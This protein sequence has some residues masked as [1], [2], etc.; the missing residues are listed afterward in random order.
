MCLKE[1]Y[2]TNYLNKWKNNNVTIGRTIETYNFVIYKRLIISFRSTILTEIIG[3]YRL[4]L[5]YRDLREKQKTIWYCYL[6]KI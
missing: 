2:I 3:I 4:I 1:R 6:H 5:F